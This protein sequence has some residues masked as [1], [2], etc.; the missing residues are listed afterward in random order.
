MDFLVPLVKKP[1]LS[2]GLTQRLSLSILGSQFLQCVPE[3][4]G[5]RTNAAMPLLL[6]VKFLSCLLFSFRS[7]FRGL[8]SSIATLGL[9][10]SIF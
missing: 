4:D 3:L 6:K 5:Q 9:F 10:S 2:D 7:S 1:T 8:F